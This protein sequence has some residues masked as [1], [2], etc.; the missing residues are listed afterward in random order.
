MKLS[1]ILAL[2]K[3]VTAI[4]SYLEQERW[5]AEGRAE[6]NAEAKK[7]HDERVAQANAARADADELS[8]LHISTD[9]RNRDNLR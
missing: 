5:K 8:G 1:I 7:A 4:M 3:I 9:P 2:L 6:V